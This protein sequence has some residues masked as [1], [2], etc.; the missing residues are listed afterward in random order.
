MFIYKIILEVT[1]DQTTVLI[2]FINP[3]LTIIKLGSNI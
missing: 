1:V 2:Y 3:R